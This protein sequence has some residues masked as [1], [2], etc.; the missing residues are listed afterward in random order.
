MYD[1]Y[2][3]AY[4][5]WDWFEK[6]TTEAL[7]LNI[8]CFSSVFDETGV[9]FLEDLG[10][11]AY[12]IASFENNHIP[13]IRKVA[14]TKKPLII[15]TGAS[16][17]D[18]IT[19]TVENA[20][21]AGCVDLALLKCTSSYPAEA[22]DSN[23]SCIPFL[24]EKFQCVVGLSDHTL[25]IGAAL[26]GIALGAS[27]I[28]KHFIVSRDQ[29]GV[30]SQFSAD[31]KEFCLMVREIENVWQAMGKPTLELSEAEQNSLMFKRSIYACKHIKKGE[32]FSKS[33]L[34]VVR[35]GYGLH[36]RYFEEI[37]GKTC[38]KELEPGDRLDDSVL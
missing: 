38:I 16:S 32:V 20:R 23:L 18:D 35:P 26:G 19:E 29:G 31:E 13:L 21:E 17:E 24:R 22:S 10:V 33:N 11:A 2:E 3:V 6:I 15:S 4:T 5:P 36:P 12:K 1:L 34:R 30:D 8:E 28:E 27:I 9:D 7:K 25:G 37:I 14:A